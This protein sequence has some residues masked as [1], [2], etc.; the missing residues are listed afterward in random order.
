MIRR[1]SKVGRQ[2]SLSNS[3][4]AN[5][6]NSFNP[7]HI[8]GPDCKSSTANG[9]NGKMAFLACAIVAVNAFNGYMTE[10]RDGHKLEM[11]WDGLLLNKE[12]YFHV[13][14]TG[15]DG[16]EGQV[17]I[18]GSASSTQKYQY[19][20]YPSF[21]HWSF[22]HQTIP[23]HWPSAPPS[24]GVELAPPSASGR[25]AHVLGRDHHC[26]LTIGQSKEYWVLQ[27]M[28]IGRLPSMFT[29]SGSIDTGSVNTFGYRRRWSTL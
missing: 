2:P 12:Y 29:T 14:S 24:S 17:G 7:S 23:A 15:G 1:Q 9:V 8:S 6:R 26:L 4:M 22:P 13:P 27:A 19:P 28:A 5:A 25:T 10:T 21:E 11:E 16:E 20:V 18:E 3:V